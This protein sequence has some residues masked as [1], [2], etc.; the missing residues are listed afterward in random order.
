MSKPEREASPRVGPG[1]AR[2]WVAGERLVVGLLALAVALGLFAVWFQWGQTRRCLDFLGP[3]AARRI[4]TADRVELWSLTSSGGRVAAAR[5]LDVSKAPGLVHL[6]RGLVED[7]NYAWQSDA[8]AGPVGR[9]P[10]AAWDVAIAFV[11]RSPP[12]TTILAFDLDDGA[13]M[14]LVGR[15][16]HV[17]LGRIGPGLRRWI[18]AVSP[19]FF[20]EKSAF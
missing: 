13:A 3:E 15:R 16:G 14:T 20:A 2:G 4:Q 10:P 12:A 19:T 7:G 11:E 8:G 1:A 6:R 9:R 5:V 17:P 18:E